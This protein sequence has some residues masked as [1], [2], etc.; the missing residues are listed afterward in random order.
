M[1]RELLDRSI[2]AVPPSTVDVARLVQRERRMRTARWSGI[3]VTAVAALAVTGVLVATPHGSAPPTVG[4]PPPTAS[5]GADNRF[6]L[7][8]LDKVTADG[9]AKR[10]ADALTSG[11]AKASP[12]TTWVPDKPGDKGAK[13]LAIFSDSDKETPYFYSGGG[14]TLTKGRQGLLN[15]FI[16]R[17]LRPQENYPKK[18]PPLPLEC[19]NEPG[20]TV[21]TGPNGERM[22][23]R[24]I[25]HG[26]GGQHRFDVRM[27]LAGGFRLSLASEDSSF[28]NLDAVPPL[29][30]DELAT[31][32]GVVAQQI[33]A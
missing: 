26:P 5:S 17:T 33:K 1:T 25:E 20:C 22:F 9:I 29:S 12:D 3:G 15:L 6:Q 16:D 7:V 14:L 30:L 18:A 11:T 28:E 31:I 27:E 2:G 21:R 10:L 4:A 32:A 8:A 24:D 19:G 13:V 23:A